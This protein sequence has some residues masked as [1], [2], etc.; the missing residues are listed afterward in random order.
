MLAAHGLN[1]RDVQVVNLDSA[2]TVAALTSKDI[3]AAFGDTQLINL[4]AKGAADIIYTT[5]GDDPRFGRNAGVI[6]R[7]AFIEAHPEITQASSMPS[8]RRR[9]G[10]PTSQI[11][12]RFSNS[13]TSPARRFRSW[14]NIS[15][16]T[17]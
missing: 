3:D 1:E 5:K 10:R 14:T 8:S 13:G 11:V 2:G 12:P 6:G 4:A 7:Q 17:R 9:N 15:A 16:T